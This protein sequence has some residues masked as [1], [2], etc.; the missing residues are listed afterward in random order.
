[1]ISLFEFEEGTMLTQAFYR[2]NRFSLSTLH[3]ARLPIRKFQ[4]QEFGKTSL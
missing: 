3:I 2:R 1:M 4:L